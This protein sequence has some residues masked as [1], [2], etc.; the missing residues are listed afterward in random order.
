MENF[1]ERKS[2]MKFDKAP[3]DPKRREVIVEGEESG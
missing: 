2:I 1:P 3:E